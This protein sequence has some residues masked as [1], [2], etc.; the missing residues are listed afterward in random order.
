MRT[1]ISSFLPRAL[2]ISAGLALFFSIIFWIGINNVLAVIAQLQWWW[3]A[4]MPILWSLNLI[5]GGIGVFAL[6]R[7]AVDIPFLTFLRYYCFSQSLGAFLPFQMGESSLVVIMRN[8]GIG[9]PRA[10]GLFLIDK[11]I[12]LLVVGIVGTLGIIFL[13]ADIVVNAFAN[14]VLVGVA[15]ALTLASIRFVLQKL[16]PQFFELKPFVLFN[17]GLSITRTELQ[18]N[19]NGIL[20]NLGM[21]M[22]KT[23]IL[24]PLYFVIMFM[25]LGSRV[26]FVPLVLLS[27]LTSLV[28]L[29]PITMQ[30]LGVVELTA[31][32]LFGLVGVAP[33]TIAS[34]YLVSRPLSFVF[35]GLVLSVTGSSFMPSRDDIRSILRLGSK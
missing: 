34:V 12:T 20:V 1:R 25:A 24:A 31:I 32:Y 13:F 17:T 28:S 14:W 6:F 19:Q 21:T 35:S 9:L 27:N 10:I 7:S 4:G 23:L 29:I 30:G 22:I 33:A 15:V 5:V 8:Q 18:V 11:I 16:H 2:R 3:L 26:P